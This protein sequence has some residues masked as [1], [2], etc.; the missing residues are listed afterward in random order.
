VHQRL[1][2]LIEEQLHDADSPPNAFWLY[3]ATGNLR[4]IGRSYYTS[5]RPLWSQIESAAFV[6]PLSQPVETVLRE[7][8]CFYRYYG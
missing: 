2:R 7:L 4:A 1:V 5:I 6:Q 8:R 3:Q